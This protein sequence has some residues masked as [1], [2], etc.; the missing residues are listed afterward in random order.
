VADTGFCKVIDQH[1]CTCA[2]QIEQ[3]AIVGVYNTS[4]RQR[5]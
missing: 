3:A 5:D 2:I 4:E 1:R